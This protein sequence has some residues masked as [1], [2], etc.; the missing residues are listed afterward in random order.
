MTPGRHTMPG[1][2]K[3]DRQGKEGKLKRMFENHR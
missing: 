2:R 1:K 3:D